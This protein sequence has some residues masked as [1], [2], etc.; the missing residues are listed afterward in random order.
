M[1]FTKEQLDKQFRVLAPT[2]Q[3]ALLAQETANALTHAGQ[4]ENL[5]NDQLMRLGNLFVGTVVGL[6]TRE[7]LAEFIAQELA[8]PAD[9][10]TRLYQALLK[11]V[12]PCTA[13]ADKR[14]GAAQL[15]HGVTLNGSSEKETPLAERLIRDPELREYAARL[16]ETVRT[17]LASST[18]AQAVDHIAA[19]Y[20][21]TD[22]QTAALRDG[23]L[24]VAVGALPIA[25]FRELIST[26]I[27]RDQDQREHLLHGL[28]EL[29][30]APVRTEILRALSSNKRSANPATTG[31]APAPQNVAA[32]RDEINRDPYRESIP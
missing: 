11:E 26:S 9:A 30:F 12:F 24:R 18:A 28:E 6:C 13:Q 8:L 21:L 1:H 17:Y 5:T 16:P 7:E 20:S 31:S 14:D 23:V 15:S 4:G 3:D 27:L 2:L 25:A 32:T 29:V 10:A 22:S 19:R